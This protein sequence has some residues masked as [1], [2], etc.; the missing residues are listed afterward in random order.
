MWERWND[1][2]IGLLLE[3]QQSGAA[4]GELRQ[5]AEAFAQVEELKR[6]DGALNLARVYFAEGRLDDAVEALHR[7]S[8][9]RSPAPP[10][11]TLA[12]LTGLV[13]RQ[14]GRLDEAI[15]NFRSVL[16]TRTDEMARRGFDFS[17]DYEV[18]NELG[19]TLFDRA[20]QER[21]ELSEA[22][23]SELLQ[24]AAV[25]FEKT[26]RIDSE[27]VTAHYNLALLF[28]RL[29]DEAKANTHREYHLRYKP[30]DN[31]RDRAIAIARKKYPAANH[32]AENVVI[33]PL[34]RQAS[35]GH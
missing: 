6:F 13:N 19:Q 5:A 35:E 34:H 17:L 24:D 33:Y 10:A 29:G 4:K 30:D 8:R 9:Y 22:R 32:A 18:I 2:G 21:G 26:L 16:E 14:Q 15:E 27:N 12:W 3:G 31:A 23:R 7:A 1:Y 11:W 20:K 28:A 25:E